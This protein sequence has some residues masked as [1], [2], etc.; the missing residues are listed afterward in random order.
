MGGI[1]KE[2]EFTPTQCPKQLKE[3]FGLNLYAVIDLTDTER[4]YDP[5]VRFTPMFN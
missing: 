4:Y 2:E 1:P 3:K 5:E